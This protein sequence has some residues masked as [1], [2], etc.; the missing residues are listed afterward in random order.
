MKFTINTTE[1]KKVMQLVKTVAESSVATKVEAKAICLLRA[2]PKE[3]KMRLDFSLKG[4]FLSYQFDNV[5]IS[6]VTEG[7][8]TGEFR[9]SVDLGVL[10]ALKFSGKT[11]SISLGKNREG[12]TIAF[13]SGKMSGK[14]VVSHADIEREVEASRPADASVELKYQFSSSM[15]QK[16]LS[17]HNYGS[18]SDSDLAVKRV[19]RIYKDGTNLLF[20]SKDKHT[21]ARIAKEYDIPSKEPIDFFILP[22]PLQAILNAASS[23]SPNFYFGANKEMW[24][25]SCG[26][27]D[28]W[29]PNVL[30][31]TAVDLEKLRGQVDSLPSF[32]LKIPVATLDDVL[33]E[34]APFTAGDTLLAKEDM[35]IVHLT[36]TKDRTYFSINTSKAKDVCIDLDDVEFTNTME[37]APLDDLMLNF[38]YLEECTKS[39]TK[40][41][42]SDTIT[43]RWWPFQNLE[44]PTKGKTVTV[45]MG[46]DY[47]WITRIRPMEG[48]SV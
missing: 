17:G 38:K 42:S 47:Y 19:V 25:L 43:L 32:S 34:L 16:A 4:S 36:V 9:R 10:A 30:M 11:V 28:V 13:S 44:S 37:E 31:Q 18:H 48:K 8:A 40:N 15:F 24:R 21:A 1:F 27:I 2:F 5:D 45:N 29:F 3:S 33:V 23:E 14:L 46:S 7:T 22:K 41:G 26:K 6:D 12:N 20:V 39:L 35:P